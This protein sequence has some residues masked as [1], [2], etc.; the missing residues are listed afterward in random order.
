MSSTPTPHH[1]VGNGTADRNTNNKPRRHNSKFIRGTGAA[2]SS[3]LSLAPAKPEY[4]KHKVLVV[5]GLD[6][7][8]NHA[9]LQQAINIRAGRE[10]KLLH[11]ESLSREKAWCNTVA[12]EVSESDYDIISQPFFWEEQIKIRPWHGVRWYRRAQ[13]PSKQEVM[14]SMRMQWQ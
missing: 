11:V 5:Q 7:S 2:V 1:S 6:K 3:E 12:I 14:S 10:I 4:L 13:R 8:V 9:K